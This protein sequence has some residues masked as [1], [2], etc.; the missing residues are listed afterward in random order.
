MAASI[1]V[2]KW[3]FGADGQNSDFT[4][5]FGMLLLVRVQKITFYTRKGFRKITHS[6]TG[7]H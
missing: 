5:I 3:D 4:I 2:E 7:Q 1:H 6:S